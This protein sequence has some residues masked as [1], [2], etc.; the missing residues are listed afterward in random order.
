MDRHNIP[1]SAQAE[2]VDVTS[3]YGVLSVM[4]PQARNLLSKVTDAD[5]ANTAFPFGTAQQ[6]GVG[7]SHVRALRITYVGELGW[8]LHTHMECLTDV[9]DT[10]WA[11]GRK[12]GVVNAGNYAIN[13]L[14]LE[15]GY[16]AW[17]ARSFHRRNAVGGW[18]WVCRGLGQAD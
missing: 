18:A 3:A 9:Y 1:A 7:M 14:R 4:G 6:I 13:A 5:L 12:L 8:E 2:L 17:G 15:K 16:L 10:L 11:A